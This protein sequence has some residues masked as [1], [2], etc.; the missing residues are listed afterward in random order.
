LVASKT[1]LR[2]FDAVSSGPADVED[3]EV[4]LPD[5]AV[6]VGVDEVQPRRRAPVAE[7]ARL[8]AVDLERPLQQRVVVEVDLADRQVVGGAPVGVHLAAQVGG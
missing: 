4:L 8:D 2:R 7:Q 1:A 6:E 3:V 5:D